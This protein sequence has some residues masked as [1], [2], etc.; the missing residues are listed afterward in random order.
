MT[1]LG[2]GGIMRLGLI[3]FLG[4]LLISCSS[5]QLEETALSP[6]ERAL[7]RGAVNDIAR[8]DVAALSKKLRPEMAGQIPSVFKQMRA[9]L[10]SQPLKLSLSDAKWNVVGSARTTEAVYIVEGRSGWALVDVVME[11]SDGRSIIAGMHVT[12]MATDPR[13]ATELNLADARA[14]GWAMLAAMAIAIGVTITALIRIWRSGSFQRRWLWTIGA[15]VGVTTLKMNWTSGEW[16]FQPLSV[17]FFSASALKQPVYSPWVLGVSL[18]LVALIA[19]FR[20]KP[21]AEEIEAD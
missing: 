11:S 4:A 12:K 16:A 14:S 10:P 5:N 2:E 3:A 13:E 6:D 18:P 19:L 15:L 17:Q 1:V 7:V 21:A 9:Q 8:D 20:R